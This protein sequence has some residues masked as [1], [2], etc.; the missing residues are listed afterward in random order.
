MKLNKRLYVII[1]LVI[2]CIIGFLSI[3]YKLYTRLT[4][5][6]D[7]DLLFPEGKSKAIILSFD[8]GNVQDTVIVRMLDKYQLKGTFYLHT[9]P[10]IDGS[11][12]HVSLN[13]IAQLYKGHELGSHGVSHNRLDHMNDSLLLHE[14]KESKDTLERYMQQKVESFAYPY[15]YYNSN[16][17]LLAKKVGYKSA[18]TIN[19]T[20]N[21]NISNEL[22]QWHPCCH[23]SKANKH[24]RGFLSTPPPYIQ[25]WKKLITQKI[26]LPYTFYRV[27]FVWG[28]STEVGANKAMSTKEFE[29]FCKTIAQHDAIW[30]CTASE[31]ASYQNCVNN[32]LITKYEV[33][34][35]N[36]NLHS[37]WF[38][39]SE[40][41]YELKPGE[42]FSI[43]NINNT[44][45]N[46][47]AYQ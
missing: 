5:T 26:G 11:T 34:N 4:T 35:P 36:Y 41:T 17:L 23:L 15:G 37:V 33:A 40:A 12:K 45:Q 38:K 25:E 1:I 31:L 28:H 16:T 32:L 22:M 30:S 10:L 13:N 27:M 14:L 46:N 47:S 20:F 3:Q 44:Q 43:K 18:R 9:K 39:F 21:Y 6:K 24:L 7:I 19:N 29:Y 8:D 2:G 42:T